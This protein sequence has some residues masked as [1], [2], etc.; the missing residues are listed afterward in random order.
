MLNVL[1]LASSRWGLAMGIYIIAFVSYNITLAFYAAIFPRLAHNTPHV[2]GVRLRYN[3]G[4]IT[5]DKYERV[6]ALEKSKISSLSMVRTLSVGFSPVTRCCL[7]LL[8][9]SASL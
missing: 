6:E 3:Q 7:R 9:P 4:E 1:Q 8:A 2:R 5:A